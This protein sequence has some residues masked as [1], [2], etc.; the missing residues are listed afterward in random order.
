M[1]MLTTD[2]GRMRTAVIK[3]FQREPHQRIAVYQ[4]R[5]R[6]TGKWGRVSIDW[7][8]QVSVSTEQVEQFIVGLQEALRIYREWERES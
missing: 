1:E 5:M 8:S 2:D 6:S 3:P 7:P 4:S